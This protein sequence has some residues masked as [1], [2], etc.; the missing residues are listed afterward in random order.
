MWDIKQKATK[1]QTKK[2]IDPDNRMVVSRRKEGKGRAR[3]AK[4]SNIW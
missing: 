4:E 3:R 1:E 2:S